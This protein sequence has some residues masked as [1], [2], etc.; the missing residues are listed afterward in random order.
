V[1][2]AR[3]LRPAGRASLHTG[4]VEDMGDESR[5]GLALWQLVALLAAGG[6]GAL[7]TLNRLIEAGAGEPQSVLDGDQGRY[8]WALGD[9]FYTVKGNGAPLVLVH[10]IY[11]G[12]SSYEYR[13]IFDLLARDFRVYAFDLL[14]FGLSDR[15]AVVYTSVL[16][17]ELIQDFV[18]QVV[19]GVDQPV[20]II[21][22]SLSAAFTVRAAAERP[23]L[24]ER[25]VLIQPTGIEELARSGESLP[26]RLWRSVLRAPVVGQ[27]IYNVIASRPSIAYFLK[28]QIYRDPR[29]VTDTM[30]QYY[31]TTAHQPG[32]RFAPASF[33]SGTLNT[34]VASVYPLLR[35]P[36]LLCWGKD[37]RFTPLENARAF[38]EA[39]PRAELRVFDCGGLPQAE[40]P[41]EFAREVR[42][43]LLAGSP[44]RTHR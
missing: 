3:G 14:G 41:E 31:Y 20:R 40:R 16:F 17:E 42:E 7:A 24:F 8:S 26:R 25:L 2:R 34:P 22:S 13:Q 37:A 30:V 10:G 23:G 27:A 15:P 1:A 43:W 35:Q 12:A 29:Q 36:I 44:S 38:R 11:A 21:A 9:I 32:A 5:R 18:R 39:N 4:K 19:G 28:S 33:I 6:V